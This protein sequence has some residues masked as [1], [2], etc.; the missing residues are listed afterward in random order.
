[1]SILLVSSLLNNKNECEKEE[2]KWRRKVKTEKQQ[3]YGNQ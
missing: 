3:K 2:N 1:M